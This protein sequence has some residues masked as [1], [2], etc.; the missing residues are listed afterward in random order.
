[1]I[2]S[3]SLQHDGDVPGYQSR[4]TRF[5]FDNA[6]VAILTNDETFGSIMQEIIKYRLA[7]A[8]FG[9]EALDLT[10]R[11]EEALQEFDLAGSP[12][13][14]APA[15]ASFPFALS[16][17]LGTYRNFGY[18]VDIELCGTTPGLKQSSTCT[19]LVARLNRTFPAQI[20]PGN[21]DL[22]F[23]WDRL[24]A[25]YVT[26]KHFDGALFNVSASWVSMPT[27]DQSA[28][29]W[30]YDAGLESNVAEFDVNAGQVVGF[31]LRGGVWAAARFVGEPQGQTVEERSEVWY[32]YILGW[33]QSSDSW[34]WL[35]SSVF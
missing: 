26:L 17:V 15:N 22:V 35:C 13:T 5:P 6:G 1:M 27:G 24:L 2:Y 8:I 34:M 31:G 3:Y 21:S 20:A 14:P 10:S 19:A 18:G 33:N 28:P 4:I 30:P 7:D 25:D 12:T 9:L 16:V 32:L 23:S 11:Y 29:F